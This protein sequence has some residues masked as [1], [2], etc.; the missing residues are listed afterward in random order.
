MPEQIENHIV[1]D[2]WWDPME[3]T[4]ADANRLKRERLAREEMERE[5]DWNG[6]FTGNY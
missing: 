5:E 2:W 6:K 4:T 1:V 3:N